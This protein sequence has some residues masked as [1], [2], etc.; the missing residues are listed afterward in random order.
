MKNFL[1]RINNSITGFRGL[2]TTAVTY[3][4]IYVS[5][6]FNNLTGINHTALKGA[7]IAAIP[8]SLKLIWTDAWPKVQSWFAKEIEIPNKDAQQK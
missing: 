4:S 1:I 3:I 5:S 8:I 7:A 2:I 6:F